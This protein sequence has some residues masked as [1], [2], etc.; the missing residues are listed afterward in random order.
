MWWER[1][2]GRGRKDP[3]GPA[4]ARPGKLVRFG[5]P[6]QLVDPLTGEITVADKHALTVAP[7]LVLD[8]P[9]ALLSD[10]RANKDK[11]LSWGGDYSNAKF[12]SIT[13]GEGQVEKG[14]HTLSGDAVAK[15]VVAYGGV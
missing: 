12:V 14:L 8:V 13:L 5:Q 3:P 15:A 7:V 11:P 9:E 1:G 2:R 6:V 4:Q 10:A